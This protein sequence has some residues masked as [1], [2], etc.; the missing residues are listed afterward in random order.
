MNMNTTWLGLTLRN[1][2]VVSPSPLCDSLD[3]LRRMEDA[4]AGA[5]VLHS[6][7]EEQINAE[8]RELDSA[9][10]RGS[11]SYSEVMSYFPDPGELS[12]GVDSYLELLRAASESLEIPVIASLN[13]VSSGGW[14]QIAKQLEQAGA[15]ALELN[16]YHIPTD[17]S[18]S[19]EDVEKLYVFLARELRAVVRLPLAMKLGP[20]F[21]G[22]ANMARRLENEQ[23]NGLVLF[24]RFYQ[25]D[26]DLENL[27]IQPSLHLS[28][29]DELLLR[30]RWTAILHGRTGLDLGITGGVHTGQDALKCMMAGARVAM[31]TSALLRN[32]IGH[33]GRVLEEMQHWMER[34]EYESISQMQGS[35]SQQAVAN[36]NAFERANYLKVLSSYIL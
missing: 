10:R 26:F 23:I 31:L 28:R 4:G 21:S 27:E 9:L 3:N 22:F 16:A 36:P 11:E 5:I 25:P 18:Q 32:G 1:P 35:M 33:L 8:S 15:A 24:N 7:F 34:K 29:S 17:P 19:G 20:Y 14:I 13:G 2:L 12:L 30:L 6:L